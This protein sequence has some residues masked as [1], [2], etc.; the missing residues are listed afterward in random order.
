MIRSGLRQ[1]VWLFLALP[2]SAVAAD[3]FSVRVSPVGITSNS[4]GIE[5]VLKYE[6][7]K[8]VK[9]ETY[10]LPGGRIEVL[11]LTARQYSARSKKR[12]VPCPAPHQRIIVDDS[13]SGESIVRPGQVFSQV[14]DLREVVSNLDEILGKCDLVLHW[15]YQPEL[16]DGLFADRAAGALVIPASLVVSEPDPVTVA[17]DQSR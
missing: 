8:P 4:A 1:V 2:L 15:S 12:P 3:S 14:I 11:D 6:G 13:G 9:A 10:S 7:D 16:R 5:I 17:V